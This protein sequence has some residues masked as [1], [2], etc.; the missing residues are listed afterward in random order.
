M[1]NAF[2]IDRRR[3]NEIQGFYDNLNVSNHPYDG[4]SSLTLSWLDFYIIE[5]EDGSATFLKNKHNGLRAMTK[6]QYFEL[7]TNMN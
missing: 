6:E 7:K 4:L 2:I 5:E 3:Y 1:K